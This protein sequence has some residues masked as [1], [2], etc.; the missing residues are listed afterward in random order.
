M[1]VRVK[2]IKPNPF[3]P[4]LSENP[5]GHN[6]VAVERLMKSIQKLT[7]WENIVARKKGKEVELAYGHHRLEAVKRLYGDK[8]E[9]DVI[10]RDFDD[11]QMIQALDK[12]NDE[13]YRHDPE[14]LLG[15]VK[16]MWLFQRD[17]VFPGENP[18]LQQIADALD[19]PLQ[20]VNR[21]I[22]ALKM[23]GE[24]PDEENEQ[25]ITTDDKLPSIR[26]YG[27]LARTVRKLKKDGI[28]VKKT[29]IKK[30]VKKIQREAET[31]GSGSGHRSVEGIVRHEVVQ[32]NMPK[33]ESARAAALP[34]IAEYLPDLGSKVDNL[35]LQ[36]EKIIEVM[37]DIPK[38]TIS[39]LLES[40][41][42]FIKRASKIVQY[43]QPLKLN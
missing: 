22:D 35:T 29:A 15:V 6:Q 16:K 3:H 37:D 13:A 26:H 40:L 4:I 28:K 9:F 25:I 8:Y 12:E 1:K 11:L 32:S 38:G 43:Y 33:T 14:F 27:E 23:R 42:K 5:T 34:K 21:A 7:F 2:D 36:L 19:R 20:A 24:L 17:S 10:I 18:T 30:A 31:G 39:T 41:S